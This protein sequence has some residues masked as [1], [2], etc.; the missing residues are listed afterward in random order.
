MSSRLRI[1]TGTWVVAL[2]T[3]CGVTALS[4]DMSLPAQPT[5]VD[6]LH[7]GPMSRS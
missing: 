2:A 6:E 7:V 1:G 5:L 4:I 3:L